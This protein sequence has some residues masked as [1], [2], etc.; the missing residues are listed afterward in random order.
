META[1]KERAAPPHRLPQGSLRVPGGGSEAEMDDREVG[2]QGGR[3]WQHSKPKQWS[4]SPPLADADVGCLLSML[5]AGLRMG[6]LR[7]N[8]FSGDS[9]PGK[10]GG[11]F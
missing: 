4:T 11:V 1:M 5:V 2:L 10:T 8:T 7:I 9:T 6:S 3:E